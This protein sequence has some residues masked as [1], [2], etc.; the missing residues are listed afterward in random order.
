M[1]IL[2]C[3]ALA[4]TC[5]KIGPGNQDGEFALASYTQD[6]HDLSIRRCL[7]VQV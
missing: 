5:L 3:V 2:L 6:A 4:E 7:L 1:I